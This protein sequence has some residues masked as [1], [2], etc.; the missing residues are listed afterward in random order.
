MTVP[1]GNSSAVYRDSRD[2]WS[3]ASPWYDQRK[4]DVTLAALPKARYRRAYHPGCSSGVLSARLAER[5]GELLSSDREPSAVAATAARLRGLPGTRAEVIDVPDE[6]PE[7][8]FDL[9]VL[10]E[11]LYRFDVPALGRLLERAAGSL[12]PGGNLVAVHWRHPEPE[13]LQTAEAAHSAVHAI[14]GLETVV[15]HDEA[16][17]LL[18]VFVRAD[19]EDGDSP[20]LYSVAAAEGLI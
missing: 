17:F 10:S 12:V 6:W 3:L 20:A 13:H 1:G 2:P 14:A 9:I 18:E 11:L 7:E 15:R 8:S 16:D 19:G 5:C 4:F